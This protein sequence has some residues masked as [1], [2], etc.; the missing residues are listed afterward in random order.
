MSIL[1][2]T[3]AIT[4]A[5]GAI[6]ALRTAI[7]L[8]EAGR[9]LEVVISPTGRTT[10]AAELDFKPGRS[11]NEFLEE[12]T[13]RT[14]GVDVVI[15]YGYE[16]LDAPPA[17]GSHPSA[18]MVV[19]PCTMKTLAAIAGGLSRSLIERAADVALKE[20]RPLVLAPRECP[21]NLVHLRNMV[22]AAEAGALIAPAAPAFYHHPESIE[23]LADFIAGR[24]LSLLGIEHQL[25]PP[26]TGNNN[27]RKE[28]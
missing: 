6:Y 7:A 13:G 1:P 10:L 14:L 26:W 17:S 23:Q 21:M 20:R 2:I 4:G 19:V 12:K 16:Q 8:I 27:E 15:E 11:F 18:G 5:S 22:K 25:F 28:R 9:S 3:L 24:I